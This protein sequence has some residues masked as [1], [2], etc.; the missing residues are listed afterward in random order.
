M[1]IILIVLLLVTIFLALGMM[2]T[3]EAAERQ[4]FLVAYS[5]TL[6]AIVFLCVY[7]W[8]ISLWM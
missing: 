1:I 5:I 6:F 4:I 7:N 8:G 3:D 2:G